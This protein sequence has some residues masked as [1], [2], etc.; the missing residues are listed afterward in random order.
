MRRHLILEYGD[1]GAVISKL[2]NEKPHSTVTVT[3]E[4]PRSVDPVPEVRGGDS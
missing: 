4:I 1:L 2:V 3:H